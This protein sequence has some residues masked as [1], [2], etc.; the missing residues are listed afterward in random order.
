M[1]WICSREVEGTLSAGS[2]RSALSLATCVAAS[3]AVGMFAAAILILRGW[4]WPM[5]I[6]GPRIEDM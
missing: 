3:A 6:H 2:N 5:G 4:R 1:C